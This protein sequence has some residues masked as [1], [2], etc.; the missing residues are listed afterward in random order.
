MSTYQLGQ[1]IDLLDLPNELLLKVVDQVAEINPCNG[2]G[3]QKLR[4]TC[5]RMQHLTEHAM[6]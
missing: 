4:Q 3:V 1:K 2:Q 5:G 6:C